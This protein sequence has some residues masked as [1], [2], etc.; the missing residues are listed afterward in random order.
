MD[1]NKGRRWILG[2]IVESNVQIEI[3]KKLRT[4]RAEADKSQLEVANELGISQQTY[5]KYEKNDSN[6]DSST[7]RK[8][9]NL[10]GVSSDYLLGIEQPA[11]RKPEQLYCVLQLTDEQIEKLAFQIVKLQA[12]K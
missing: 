12:E 1:Y 11:Q 9:C 5:S 2:E 4:L 7:I 3:A 6:I 10:Y 8:L